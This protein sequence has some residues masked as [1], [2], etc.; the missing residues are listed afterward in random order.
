MSKKVVDA[1]KAKSIICDLVELMFDDYRPHCQ[2]EG[3][4][5]GDDIPCESSI[6]IEE[7]KQLWCNKLEEQQGEN[8]MTLEGFV[9]SFVANNTVVFLYKDEIVEEEGSHFHNYIKLW[10]GM[11][12]QILSDGSEQYFKVH[13]DVEVCPYKGCT[14]CRIIKSFQGCPNALDEVA[15]VIQE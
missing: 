14:V 1:D 3:C 9:K 15:L 11:D 2:V 5:K 12:W 8:K 6:C 7:N 13:K 10:K 4:T